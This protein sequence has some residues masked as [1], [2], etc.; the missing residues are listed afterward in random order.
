[1]AEQAG[2]RPPALLTASSGLQ[3]D[4]LNTLQESVRGSADRGLLGGAA[5]PLPRSPALLPQTLPSSK[6]T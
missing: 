6:T 1:M 4:L 5:S 2:A 3:E